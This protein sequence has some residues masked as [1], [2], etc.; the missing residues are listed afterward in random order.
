[1]A[2]GG[3]AISLCWYCFITDITSSP[4]WP[5]WLSLQAVY[6]INVRV[7]HVD[8]IARLDLMPRSFGRLLAIRNSKFKLYFILE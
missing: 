2:V 1:M 4:D 8:S 7:L 5:E 3:L 6:N